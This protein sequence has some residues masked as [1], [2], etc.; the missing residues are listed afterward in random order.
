MTPCRVCKVDT[1]HTVRFTVEGQDVTTVHVCE[2]CFE[3]VMAEFK[4]R[5]RQF[6]LLID[7]GVSNAAA[8]RIMRRRIGL[9]GS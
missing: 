1:G 8:N 5:D 4:Q 2:P 6:R 3:K 9:G 7:N